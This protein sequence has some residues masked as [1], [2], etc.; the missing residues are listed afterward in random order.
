M[1][2]QRHGAV[3]AGASVELRSLATLSAARR[4]PFGLQLHSAWSQG[5]DDAAAEPEATNLEEGRPAHRSP[6][7][8]EGLPALQ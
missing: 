1:P 7:E 2:A 6:R 4:T 8:A 3:V 5:A